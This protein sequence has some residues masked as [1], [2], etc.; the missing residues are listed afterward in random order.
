MFVLLFSHDKKYMCILIG[1]YHHIME[2]L[3]HLIDGIR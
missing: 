3:S 2:Y 1:F